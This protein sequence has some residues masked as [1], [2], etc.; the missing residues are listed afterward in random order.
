MTTIPNFR[1]FLDMREIVDKELLPFA[2]EWDKAGAIPKS[3]YKSWGE[4]GLLAC[5][6]GAPGW[7]K[8]APT[9]PPCGIPREKWD[10]F[11]WYVSSSK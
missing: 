8:D 11:H 6:S 3:V 5:F 4:R 7:P 1:Y 2:E 9:P 10:T